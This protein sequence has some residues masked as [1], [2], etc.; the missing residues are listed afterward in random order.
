MGVVVAILDMAIG[1]GLVLVEWLQ[2]TAVVGEGDSVC[3]VLASR[4]SE[5]EIG[6]APGVN[7]TRQGRLGVEAGIGGGMDVTSRGSRLRKL[8]EG[9]RLVVKLAHFFRH[10]PAFYSRL[11]ALSRNSLPHR[12]ITIPIL[13]KLSYI[14]IFQITNK[15]VFL[16]IFLLLMIISDTVLKVSTLI[17]VTIILVLFVLD[18]WLVVINYLVVLVLIH[19]I[20]T[21]G[22]HLIKRGLL[23]LFELL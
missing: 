9:L 1:N 21:I 12:F 3:L 19:V 22:L 5:S 20:L 6:L 13:F 10:A 15:L 4:S 8:V 11:S 23:H 16:E 14:L 18:I 7:C 2:L 17:G